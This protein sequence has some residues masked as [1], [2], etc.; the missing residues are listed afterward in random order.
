MSRRGFIVGWVILGLTGIALEIAAL[1][2]DTSGD[3]LSELARTVIHAHPVLFVG[4]V[5]AWLW[6]FWHLFLRR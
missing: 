5:L 3:T 4:F 6:G 1:V 2:N